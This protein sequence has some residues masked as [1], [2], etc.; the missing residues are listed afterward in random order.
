MGQDKLMELLD[1]Q[2]CRNALPLFALRHFDPQ[3][4]GSYEVADFVGVDGNNR[5]GVVTSPVG[6]PSVTFSRT[7]R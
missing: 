3:R 4:N 2:F 7:H 1:T 5:E 6:L